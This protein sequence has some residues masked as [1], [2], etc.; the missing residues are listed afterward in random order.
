MDKLKQM[1]NFQKHLTCL[2]SYLKALH[3]S[4]GSSKIF[5]ESLAKLAVNAAEGGSHDIGKK[6]DSVQK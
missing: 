5:I 1:D 6:S 4:S 3:A 2:N